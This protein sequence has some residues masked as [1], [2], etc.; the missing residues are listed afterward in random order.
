MKIQIDPGSGFC[1]G[2]KRAIKLAEI[3]LVDGHE[4]F[5]LG[6]IVHNS[7]EEKRLNDLGM[8]TI[9]HA[10]LKALHGKSVLIRAHG[11]PPSTYKIAQENRL[12]LI[13]ATCPIVTKLQQKIRKVWEEGRGDDRQIVIVGKKDHP[14]VIGLA[15]QTEY[16]AII[17]ETLSDVEKICPSKPVY[18]FAQ[19]TASESF[20]DEVAEKITHLPR[21]HLKDNIYPPQS[22][23][24]DNTHPPQSPLKG[25]GR[26]GNGGVIIQRSICNHVKNRKDQLMAFAGEHDLVIFVGGK[27]SSNGQY[28]YGLCKM[29][30]LNSVYIENENMLE[31]EWLM[32]C[33]SVGITGATSTPPWLLERVKQRIEAIIKD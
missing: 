2:V 30:N 32:G 10:E 20:F 17:I 19:T 11:E 15:G 21:P 23:L 27:N 22:P 28:L 24:K 9:N 4:V 25:G 18:L 5:S 33:R 14:E 6:Q 7:S 29:V 1:F 8:K 16:Q 26:P 12:N 3:E 13:E 31:P